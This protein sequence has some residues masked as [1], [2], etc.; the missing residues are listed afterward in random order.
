M[1]NGHET[2]D[3]GPWTQ[4]NEQHGLRGWTLG[5]IYGIAADSTL[6]YKTND[7]IERQT[8][9]LPIS[10]KAP[11]QAERSRLTPDQA[12][13]IF[14]EKRKKTSN[15][16][17]FLAAQYGISAKAIRD[18]WTKRSWANETRPYWTD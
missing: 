16:A 17:A 3:T 10:T 5:E 6:S 2:V 18:V 14:H 8:I 9:A 1:N 7:T 4:V 13:H 15:T 11:A 12:I